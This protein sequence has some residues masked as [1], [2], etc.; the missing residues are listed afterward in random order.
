MLVER[1]ERES[2]HWSSPA[3]GANHVA[4]TPVRPELIERSGIRVVNAKATSA[5]VCVRR[6]PENLGRTVRRRRAAPNLVFVEMLRVFA[7]RK[8]ATPAQIALAWL[9]VQKPWIVPIPGINRLEHLKENLASVDVV[10]TSDD[11]R[12]IDRSASEIEVTGARLSS[13]LMQLSES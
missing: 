1:G 8:N 5:L 4:L 12:E 7:A 13:E 3:E 10:L 2:G 9:L 11:L 6:E